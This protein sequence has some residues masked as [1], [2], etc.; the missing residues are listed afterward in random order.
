MK[1]LAIIIP[2][3]FVL[4]A[5]TKHISDLNVDP[6]R[7]LVVPSYT[8]FSN[9]QKNLVDQVTSSSVNYNVFRLLS[10][11]WTETT[12]TDESNYNL[13]TRT[14]PDQVWLV[15]YQDVLKDFQEAKKYIP[16]DVIDSKGV[17]NV[18]QQ[19]NDL[20]ITEVME[21][22]AYSNLVNTF[23]D[24]PYS[25]AFDSTNLFPKYDDA[26]TVYADLL[27]RL[28]AAITDLNVDPG[29]GSFDSPFGSA[30]L[31]YGGDVTKWIKFANSLKLKLGMVL[32][33][34][35]PATAKTAVESAVAAGVFTSNDD[36]AIFQYLGAQPNTNPIYLD[37]VASGRNDFVPTTTLI[38]IM[39][40]LDDPRLP[41]FFTEDPN[42]SY[43]GGVPGK[44]NT[45][46]NFSHVADEIKAPAFPSDLLDYSEVSF[47]L[48]EGKERGMNTGSGSAEDYYNAAITASIEYWGGS[49]GD[50][51]TY[52]AQTGVAYSTATGDYKQKIGTQKWIALYNRGFDAYTEQRRFD[53][54]VLAVPSK[55]TSGFPARFPYPIS[56]QNLNQKNY[57]AASAAIG[58]DKVTTKLFWDKF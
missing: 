52:L 9:A 34:S 23:G 5:C 56:E 38:N 32:A 35:D 14:I 31:L 51:T 12:Y 30:D 24:I 3:L 21:V 41:A 17:L 16:I 47:L 50:A 40:P 25:Q 18:P 54:P 11:Q 6:K 7:P 46:T 55:A 39:K 53:Y 43:S 58:G 4:G 28:D 1:K 37:L 15:F 22:Y 49:A 57:E 42:G 33:D 26:K 19:K 2:S 8:L 10:Q 44:G 48:A 45:Y 13:T 20:A 29:A 36:N 27:K